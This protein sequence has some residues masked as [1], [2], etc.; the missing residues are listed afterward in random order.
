MTKR[1]FHSWAR[2]QF[3]R[4]YSIWGGL[5]AR[6]RSRHYAHLDPLLD[7]H[8]ENNFYEF[9]NELGGPAPNEHSEVDRIDNNRGYVRGNIRWTDHKTNMWNSRSI[10]YW[11]KERPLSIVC[12]ERGILPGTVLSRLKRGW[13]MEEAVEIPAKQRW[14]QRTDD[15]IRSQ[16]KKGKPSLS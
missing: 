14:D 4:E 5:R 13:T 9:L 3:P 11:Y 10:K 15:E 1:Y 6:R 12:A 8:I 2:K 16:W 7:E